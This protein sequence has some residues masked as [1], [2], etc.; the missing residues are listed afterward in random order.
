M[1]GIFNKKRRN[2]VIPKLPLY[3]SKIICKLQLRIATYLRIQ[4]RKINPK[5]KIILIVCFFILA[6]SIH[7]F[8]I[9][10]ISTESLKKHKLP[11][12]QKSST[13]INITLPDSLDI[14]LI[15]QYRDMKRKQD[16]LNNEEVK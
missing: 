13:P 5:Q 8:K 14:N 3:P 9:I 1:F 7:V 12:H 15:R 2:N 11:S 16:S 6:L 10:Q 4:E